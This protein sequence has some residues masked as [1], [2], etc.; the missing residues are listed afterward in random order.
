MR[1]PPRSTAF[2]PLLAAV[3]LTGAHVA[4]ALVFS[5]ETTIREK[6]VDGAMRWD[7]NFYSSIMTYGYSFPYPPTPSQPPSTAFFPFYPLASWAVWK[8]TGVGDRVAL[9]LVSQAACVAAWYLLLRFLRHLRVPVG[10]RIAACALLWSY[11]ASYF[12]V[13]GY[14]ESLFMLSFIGMVFAFRALAGWKRVAFTGLPAFVMASTRVIGVPLL[15]YPVAAAVLLPPP[16]G[17]TRFRSILQGLAS[18]AIGSLGFLAYIAYTQARFGRADAFLASQA[19]WEHDRT[20]AESVQFILS[21]GNFMN[22][23][24][25]PWSS[26]EFLGSLPGF[27]MQAFL[28]GFAVLALRDGWVFLRTRSTDAAQRLLWYAMSLCM[29]ATVL[30]TVGMTGIYVNQSMVRYALMADLWFIVSAAWIAAGAGRAWRWGL[31]AVAAAACVLFASVELHLLS[32][33]LRTE[34]FIG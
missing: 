12:L 26:Q 34:L 29:L 4:F 27:A 11:P 2:L 24:S 13:L 30:F 5:P 23:L 3:A 18:S 16:A 1:F 19:A 17:T 20:V 32:L 15:A 28:V 31:Y 33:I 9:L 10:L 14:T 21:P 8:A 25:S 22:V 6:Y 7:S